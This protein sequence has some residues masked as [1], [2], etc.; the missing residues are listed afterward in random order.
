[1]AQCLTEQTSEFMTFGLAMYVPLVENSGMRYDMCN[2]K[3]P[4]IPYL[5]DP[6]RHQEGC[7]GR[8]HARF[9]NNE[10]KV[11]MNIKNQRQKLLSMSL[12]S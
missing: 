2:S 6:F 5:E 11:E 3:W 8:P 9:K 12:I 7:E 1:M 4:I 10:A